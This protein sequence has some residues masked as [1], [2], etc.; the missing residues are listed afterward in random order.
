MY[1]KDFIDNY[2]IVLFGGDTITITQEQEKAFDLVFLTYYLT[3]VLYNDDF[4]EKSIITKS[5][6]SYFIDFVK[7]DMFIHKKNGLSKKNENY[8]AFEE[9]EK[10]QQSI[11]K[12]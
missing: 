8:D 9:I 3:S 1:N 6:K 12:N 5:I 10:M 2:S 11:Y 4:A 7:S